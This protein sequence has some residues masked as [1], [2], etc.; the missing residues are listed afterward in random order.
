M[1]KKICREVAFVLSLVI[2]SGGLFAKTAA[3]P[4]AQYTLAVLPLEISGRV[5]AEEG[6]TLTNRLAAEL[7]R[8]GI[9][10]VTDQ[11]AVQ[12]TLQA[13]GLPLTACSSVDCGMQ[14]G[15]LL[16]TQLVANGS[17]RKV[18]QLYFVEVQL[19]HS[20]SGRVVQNV[21]EDFDGDMR[22]LLNFMTTVARKL[23]GKS[24]ATETAGADS[25]VPEM[26]S[27]AAPERSGMTMS[28]DT[29]GGGS[30][31]STPAPTSEVRSGGGNKFLYIG[32]AAVGAAGAVYGITQ[33]TKDS[34]GKNNGKTGPSTDLPNPPRFP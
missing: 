5:T 33:L 12:S 30:S 15:K 20:N 27:A 24:A 9:F 3:Q 28:N 16:A 13:A 26:Q 10:I 2:T 1:S 25:A 17:I 31:G 21:N 6:A 22:Q 23:V 7:A 18:G 8:T 4:A 14:A 11:S 29:Y 34:D 32:L 19:L